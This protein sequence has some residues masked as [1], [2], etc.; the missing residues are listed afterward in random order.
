MRPG[1][2]KSGGLR[3]AIVAFCDSMKVV[4]C[5]AWVRKD[6]PSNAD[7]EAAG[8]LAAGHLDDGDL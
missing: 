3:F 4:L 6:D 8:D 1:S 5:R 7:F 2:G